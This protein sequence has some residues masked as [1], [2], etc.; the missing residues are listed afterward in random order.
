MVFANGI[1]PRVRCSRN[2]Y[3][4]ERTA[5]H[6][7]DCVLDYCV[8]WILAAICQHRKWRLKKKW[9]STRITFSWYGI[10]E[11]M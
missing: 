7:S 11:K 9:F 2:V 6:V 8:L 3:L 10:V 4:F 1:N 5:K